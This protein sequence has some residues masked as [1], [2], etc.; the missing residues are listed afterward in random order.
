MLAIQTLRTPEGY[1]LSEKPSK[2]KGRRQQDSVI[3]LIASVE[4]TF[5]RTKRLYLQKR[6]QKGCQVTPGR[7]ISSRGFKL[8]PG[9]QTAG[10]CIMSDSV[11]RDEPPTC[12][13]A[14][15]PKD[16]L[17]FDSACARGCHAGG[18]VCMILHAGKRCSKQLKTPKL[19]TSS[20]HLTLDFTGDR[21]N[22][23][24]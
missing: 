1:T 24:G 22:V 7:I 11:R 2:S 15:T 9:L 17:V 19:I 4:I 12:E 5:R 20:Q 21:L 8:K 10:Q 3:C 6:D 18:C 23:W 13:D 14:V 16:R